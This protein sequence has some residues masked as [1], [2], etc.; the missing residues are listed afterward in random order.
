[1]AHDWLWRDFARKL[2][3]ERNELAERLDFQEKLNRECIDQ[4]GFMTDERDEMTLQLKRTNDSL[5]A[6]RTLADRLANA[7]NAT[8]WDSPVACKSAFDTW[9]D[10][11]GLNW[12]K[13]TKNHEH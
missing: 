8:R 7:L 1:M 9:K 10:E 11:R 12:S 6:E 4:I 2:E 3:R 13:Q 5:F